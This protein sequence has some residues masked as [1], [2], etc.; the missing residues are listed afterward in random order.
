MFLDN[1]KEPL[2]QAIAN[3][4]ISEKEI[5]NSIRGSLRV[6]LKLGLLDQSADNPYA[7]IG[8]NDTIAPWTKAETHELVR[9]ATVESVVL[10]KNDQQ[11][12][13]LKTEKIKRIAVIGPSAKKVISDWYAGTPPYAVTALQGIKNAVG[14]AVEIS[15]ASSNKADSAVIAAKN[16]DV[17]IVC[18]GNH[19][20]GYGLP[21]GQNY[22][23]S[24]GRE[25]V[26]RQAISLE[27]E[28]LVKLVYKANP[29]TVLVLVSS[30]PYT[31]NW[32]KEHVPAILHISQSSQ[33]LGNGLA[34]II[35][36]KSS[37]AGRLV[38]TWPT[39]IDQLLPILDYDIRHGRTYMYDKNPSLFPFGHGLTYTTFKY[40]NLKT[41]KSVKEGETINVT[42]NLENTG[43]YDSDEVVQ[44][45]VKFPESKVERPAIAL[46]GF[47]RVSV[48]KG[49][50]MKV[51]IPLNTDELKYWDA[52][53]HAFI[54]EKGK[55]YIAVGA[56]S[57][58]LRLNTSFV[59]K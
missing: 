10:L 28:D 9:K 12:L 23:P 21:W 43:N 18:V 24:D 2:K 46:K 32:S 6:M 48:A 41:N 59:V 3:G 1:Y 52:E 22:V 29:N 49:K 31:I 25:D 26:D 47:K 15:Y 4:L 45:Y 51:T 8:I 17:A 37:P 55:V 13:P 53:K 50:S 19:P 39:S 36:G 16:A 44:L 33:E 11:L 34:D 58:D 42:L 35:F 27:Q 38:Q 57:A 5:D 54:L 7:N 56:S 14:S 20:L 40:S 30:F